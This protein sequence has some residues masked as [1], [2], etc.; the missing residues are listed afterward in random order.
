[1]QLLLH[2][3]ATLLSL[4]VGTSSVAVASKY[5]KIPGG[6]GQHPSKVYPPICN[7]SGYDRGHNNLIDVLIKQLR[8]RGLGCSAMPG[9]RACTQVA[10]TGPGVAIFL[11]N[12]L[13]H[14]LEVDCETVADYAQDIRDR[15]DNFPLTTIPY[16]QGQEFDTGGWNVIVGGRSGDCE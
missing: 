15:C 11:C 12:D 1:M 10:C 8:I 9:P 14:E 7:I 2:Q 16:S 5:D 13:D 6:Q 3:V 4:A